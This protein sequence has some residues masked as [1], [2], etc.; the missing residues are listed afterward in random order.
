MFMRVSGLPKTA[1]TND[2][3]NYKKYKQEK[4]ID[5]LVW[6]VERSETQFKLAMADVR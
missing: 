3:C 1:R 6:Q 5:T 4:E 2:I